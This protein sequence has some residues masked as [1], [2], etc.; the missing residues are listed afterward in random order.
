M[1]QV[2]TGKGVG[3]RE[4][5]YPQKASHHQALMISGKLKMPD[6]NATPPFVPQPKKWLGNDLGWQE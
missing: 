6:A 3:I 1:I 2:L 4:P 5:L